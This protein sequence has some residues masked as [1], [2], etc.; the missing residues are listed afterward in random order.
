MSD[1]AKLPDRP[2]LDWY[3]KAAKKRLNVLRKVDP[4]A[5]LADA[6][7]AVARQH[8]FTSWRKLKSE[9][10][11]AI[12]PLVRLLTAAGEGKL[13]AA[14]DVLKA[15]PSLL[16]AVDATG[17]AA[18]HA[19]VNA[20]YRPLTRGHRDVLRYLLALDPNLEPMADSGNIGRCGE[21]RSSPDPVSW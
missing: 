21:S 7:L 4:R 19:A 17:R 13:A 3:R 12:S 8:G 1:A 6:Q 2:N 20:E 16:N 10:D 11:S 9:I 15:D 18:L 14:R 5:K